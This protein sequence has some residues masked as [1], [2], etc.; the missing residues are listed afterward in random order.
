MRLNNSGIDLRNKINT[1][2][3]IQEQFGWSSENDGY[4]EMIM[5]FAVLNNLYNNV[6]LTE[7]ELNKMLEP[8]GY[9]LEE[10]SE[11]VNQYITK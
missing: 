4:D 7:D 3:E 2:I 5:T 1:T 9:T 11:L 8:N 10:V 6:N